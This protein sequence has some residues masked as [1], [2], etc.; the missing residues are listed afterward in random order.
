MK[1]HSGLSQ[2]SATVQSPGRSQR[3]TFAGDAAC[4]AGSQPCSQMDQP[5]GL[6]RAVVH[7]AAVSIARQ[8]HG[9]WRWH[10]S[11]VPSACLSWQS[12]ACVGA[13]WP[14]LHVDATC[15]SLQSLAL[16]G[17]SPLFRGESPPAR[18][19]C[20]SPWRARL[21]VDAAGNAQQSLRLGRCVP[22]L[23]T[24]AQPV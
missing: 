24:E 3:A 9:P 5:P 19:P 15:I 12:S 16:W 14:G 10:G 6:C 11:S 2:L 17:H 8:S 23:G 18:T 7:A 21:H 13:F 20:A 1:L 4:A 22:Y